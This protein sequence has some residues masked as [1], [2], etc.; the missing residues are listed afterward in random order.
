MRK[1]YGQRID[2]ARI[3]A[4]LK[5]NEIALALRVKP[6]AVSQWIKEQTAPRPQHLQAL[7]LIL[8]KSEN[9]LRYGSE[10]SDKPGEDSGQDVENVKFAVVPLLDLDLVTWSNLRTAI[11]Q[12]HAGS[13]T[14]PV[15]PGL[16]HG[17]AFTIKD[18]SML[19]DYAPGDV[20]IVDFSADFSPGELAIIDC[21][22]LRK[23][24]FRK[25]QHREGGLFALVPL[26]QD[27]ETLT[28]LRA[29]LNKNYHVLGALERHIRMMKRRNA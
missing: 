7:S 1:G 9:Y 26:N 6:Q 21:Q 10:E 5:K 19:P 24:I 23:T 3:A 28:F 20:I 8:K 11:K 18:R 2:Q 14:Y 27:Y 4:G 13:H 12:A 16:E 22:P 17:A 15:F 29:E 25:I